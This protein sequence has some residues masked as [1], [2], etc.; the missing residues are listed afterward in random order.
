MTVQ[1]QEEFGG[2]GEPMRDSLG[3]RR[4]TTIGVSTQES[5]TF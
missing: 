3:S 4:L 2:W 5:E 1:K